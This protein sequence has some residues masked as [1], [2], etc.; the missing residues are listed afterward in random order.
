MRT[1][2]VR[3]GHPEELKDCVAEVLVPGRG[4][5]FHQ[6]FRKRGHGPDGLY[7]KQHGKMVEAGTYVLVP[8]NTPTEGER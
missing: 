7:C 4:I 1:Y 6:C 2:G 3:A 8:R 5:S